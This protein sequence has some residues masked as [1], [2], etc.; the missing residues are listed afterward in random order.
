M[1]GSREKKNKASYCFSLSMVCVLCSEANPLH[2]CPGGLYRPTPRGY[3]C[4]PAGHG[5]QPSVS[6]LAGFSAGRWG[7]PTGGSRRL[8][9]SWSTGRPHCLGVLSAAAYCSLASDDEGFVEVSVATVG[10]LGGSHC[11]LTSSCLLNGAPASRKGVAGFWRPATLLADWERP[12]RL[13]ASLWLKGPAVLGP[14]RSGSWMTSR[15]AWLQCRA[16][17]ETAVPYGLL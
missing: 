16:A 10:R 7:P 17:R 9:A 2:G 12:G 14:Y 3:N 8:P 5:S 13:H 15:L 1:L 11:S 6:V 4:N